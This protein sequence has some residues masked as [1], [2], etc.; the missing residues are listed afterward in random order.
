MKIAAIRG[1]N[2]ASLAGEFAVEL[3]REPLHDAGLFAI[4]G[5]IGAGKS[6]ILDALC[7]ALFDR[8]PR[9]AN[10]STVLVG[11][12]E[13]E[14]A[15][16][17]GAADVRSLLRR[18]T[19]SGHAEVDFVG[20][21]GGLYRARWT[22]RRARGRVDGRFQPQQLSLVE[23]GSGRILGG[24][25]SETLA[26][27]EARLGLS[28][29]QF[30]R[31]ALLAQGQFAA[32]L[33]ADAR[34]RAELLERM[35]GT[36]IYGLVSQAAYRRAQK[37]AV[38]LADLERKIAEHAVLADAE[39]EALEA[40]R[41]RL[42][43]E[44]E[45]RAVALGR[46][47]AELR[48]YGRAAELTAAEQAARQELELAERDW[49]QG[50]GACAELEQVLRAQPARPLVQALRRAERELAAAEEA[51]I[52]RRAAATATALAAAAA[53]EAVA[54][55][56]RQRDAALAAADALEPLLTEARRLDA[57]LEESAQ[58][59][60][61]LGAARARSE[62]ELAAAQREE[63]GLR[64][65]GRALREALARTQAWLDAHDH[66][67]VL[68]AQWERW[69][70]AL[71]RYIAG[72]AQH[73]AAATDARTAAAAC[74]R[75]AGLEA[76][77]R[78]DLAAA[79]AAV[80]QAQAEADGCELAVRQQPVEPVRA[81]IDQ[82]RR[83]RDLLQQLVAA[84]GAAVQLR[85]QLT[86]QVRERDACAAALARLAQEE[87]GRAAQVAQLEAGR[88]EAEAA[89]DRLR[90]AAELGAHRGE[91]VAGQPCPLCGACEHPWAGREAAVDALL[92][93]QRARVVELREARQRAEAELLELR[94]RAGELARRRTAA[95][96][97]AAESEAGL[98]EARARADRL[99]V[100]LG[101]LAGLEDPADPAVA[102]SLRG[103][104]EQL[105]QQ[106]TGLDAAE[107]DATRHA[108]AL[109]RA[110]GVVE[111]RRL[112]VEEL[113][114]AQEEAAAAVRTLERRHGEAV[115]REQAGLQQCEGAL[116]ELEEAF[117]AADAPGARAARPGG[118]DARAEE[119]GPGAAAPPT[120]PG[121]A[122]AVAPSTGASPPDGAA[123]WR[124][125]L[126]R[127]PRGWANRL[128][129]QVS[130][131]RRQRERAE[132]DGAELGRLEVAVAAAT[133]R[134]EE[135]RALAAEAVARHGE[136]A[137]R[138]R[139]LQVRRSELLGGRAVAE[140]LDGSRAATER[141]ERVLE[142][143]RAAQESTREAA[144]R[145]AERAQAAEASRH[146]CV[147]EKARAAAE[148]EEMQR[149][150]GLAPAALDAL[151]GRDEHWLAA[152][153]QRAEALDRRRERALAVVAERATQGR[154]HEAERASTC[155]CGDRAAAEAARVA[156]HLALE[157]C[158]ARQAQVMAQLELDDRARASRQSTARGLAT[159]RAR[160]ATYRALAEL[161][162]SA[163][164]KRFRVFAQSLTL[165]R[166]LADANCKL[167]ELSPR[168]RLE[169]VPGHDL[170]IQVIDRDMGDEVRG[171]NSLS[172]GESFLVSLALSLALSAL[173]ARDTRVDSLLIDEGFG[174]LDPEALEQALAVLDTLQA[175][176]RQVGIIS[177][178]PGLAERIGLQVRVS[179]R[180]GGRSVVQVGC[181]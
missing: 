90:L 116:A 164:G 31:S 39:R 179:P 66:I 57:G 6:T 42:A 35:T 28:F 150:L 114:R 103:R 176:G 15:L 32:F 4:T 1:C 64:E 140:V 69:R 63:G 41:A 12:A 62:G 77:R 3:D 52:G 133:R 25:R 37:E 88:V 167:E 134:L 94:A 157:E 22:V 67:A 97:Q 47:D 180:G 16:R 26:A 86:A 117:A 145:A 137:A 104:L 107:R 71:A 112:E 171:V 10:R 166:L 58:R 84:V 30:C 148:L 125:E 96:E 7:V 156:L 53:A 68:A 2:L 36:E 165:D 60:L 177:H 65:R 101:E 111:A 153:R 80:A 135:A 160:A 70:S 14:E 48:W 108:A 128:A 102:Q 91:L 61:E 92:A 73:R 141:A 17:L 100:E 172:G 147:T 161:I 20:G 44:C 50:A 5:P 34:E 46:I 136:H 173:S 21:D 18:G 49:Q 43:G 139:A 99:R 138:H 122:A 118:G 132:R 119:A 155:Q 27:I 163:D 110:R 72:D 19:G 152:S 181:H 78:A 154:A 40:E 149:A 162:G 8:T 109:L 98:G 79:R 23:L 169:R 9:L 106:L 151:L 56:T 127:D 105:E 170:E 131:Y 115:V 124:A 143:R 75:A 159:A 142:Q 158:R 168:Y 55:A 76:Q 51:V 121:A 129:E 174:T 54:V 89:L 123:G 74:A 83:R 38:E 33:R 45:Q 144:T 146:A 130:G 87:A 24:T 59:G 82:G 85:G 95:E 113:L 178:V 29:E 13:E 126:A 11:R 120:R 81:A 93:A 175:A